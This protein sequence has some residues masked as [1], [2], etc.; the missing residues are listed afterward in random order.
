MIDAIDQAQRAEEQDRAVALE[1]HRQRVAESYEPRRPGIEA[2]CI[3]CDEP[4]ES[5][6]LHV[7]AGKTSRCASCAHDHELRLRSHR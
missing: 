7:L 1:R 6:R 5:E 4:I 3:D 2:L